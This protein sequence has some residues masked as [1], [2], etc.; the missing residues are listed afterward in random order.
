MET[1]FLFYKQKKNILKKVKKICCRLK[2]IIN[3][4]AA[5]KEM[6]RRQDKDKTFIENTEKRISQ[7]PKKNFGEFY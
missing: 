5:L 4:A 6:E 2:I 1:F 3:F 7:A